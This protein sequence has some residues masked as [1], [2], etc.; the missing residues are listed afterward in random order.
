MQ[1]GKRLNDPA[2]V[3]LASSKVCCL[4]YSPNAFKIPRP[5]RGEHGEHELTTLVFAR[6]LSVHLHKTSPASLLIVASPRSSSRSYS[7]LLLS[8]LLP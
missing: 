1:A 5:T 7:V 4:P 3:T 8:L 2:R 6:L